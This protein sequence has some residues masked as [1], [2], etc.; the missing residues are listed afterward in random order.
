MKELKQA[1]IFAMS[2]AWY[3]TFSTLIK[4]QNQNSKKFEIYNVVQ[5]CINLF[6]TLITLKPPLCI[7]IEHSVVKKLK[8]A[9]IFAMSHACCWTFS[10]L[11]TGSFSYEHPMENWP[12]LFRQ[13][14][15][16]M[17]NFGQKASEST[18]GLQSY[19]S[20]VLC[21]ISYTLST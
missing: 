8:R 1:C 18:Y 19:V 6:L 3:W 17:I 15:L 4:F 9:W 21:Q 13:T 12:A 2:H 20:R 7:I 16:I 14:S 11:V 5:T 10:S